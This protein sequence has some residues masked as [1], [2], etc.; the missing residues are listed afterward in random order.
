MR[1]KVQL[2]KNCKIEAVIK[3]NKIFIDEKP[4]Q[5]EEIDMLLNNNKNK[6]AKLLN[7]QQWNESTPNTMKRRSRPTGSKS[8]VKPKSS[9][10]LLDFFSTPKSNMESQDGN[11]SNELKE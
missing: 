11:A 7:S 9:R 8:K 4:V 2:L 10:Q 1:E 5:M 6:K 3:Y